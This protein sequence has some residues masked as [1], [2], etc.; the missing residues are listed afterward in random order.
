MLRQSTL[1]SVFVPIR[2]YPMAQKVNKPAP[3]PTIITVTLP[4]EDKL[5]RTGQILIQRGTLATIRQFEY[6][7]LDD[8]MNAIQDSATWLIQVEENPPDVTPAAPRPQ[9]AGVTSEQTPGEADP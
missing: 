6:T 3:A 4:E 9:A 1:I 7:S 5:L 8:I 2:R